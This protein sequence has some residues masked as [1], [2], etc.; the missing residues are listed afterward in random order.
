MHRL[1]DNLT[2]NSELF[3]F[4][5]SVTV[6]CEIPSSDQMISDLAVLRTDVRKLQAAEVSR[7]VTFARQ[8]MHNDWQNNPAAIFAK[9]NPN[10]VAPTYIL[11]DQTGN[12]TGNFRDL[13][14]LLKDAWLPI[15]DKYSD[16]NEPSWEAF[17]NRYQQYFV[18]DTR[19]T[20]RPFTVTGLRSVLQKMKNR[21]AAGP[22][23]W[24]PADL[25][26]LPDNILELVVNLFEAIEAHKQWPA[27]MTHG[28]CCL[29]PKTSGDFSPLG[30]RPLGIMSTLYRLFCCFRL[31]DVLLWQESILHQD[32]R[33]FRTGHSCD[34]IYY[35][36]ALSIEEALLNG[37]DLIGLHFDYQKAFDLIPRNIIFRLAKIQG[38]DP[39]LLAV[40]E[41]MYTR[42]QRYFKI[43]GGHSAPFVSSCGILQG[44]PLSVV[45][46]NIL[47]AIWS[48][49][50]ARESSAHPKAF[51]DDSMALA[52]NLLTAQTAMD[53]TGEVARLTKQQLAAH[54]TVAWATSK[55]SRV[56][57]RKTRFQ[58][59]L[60]QVFS[61]IKALELSSM[62]PAPAELN[63]TV[64]SCSKPLSWLT[65]SLAFHFQ[66]KIADLFV[67]QKFSPLCYLDLNLLS[68]PNLNLANFAVP[69][70]VLFGVRDPVAHRTSF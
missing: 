63:I 13:Q 68:L 17:Q 55:E 15:F 7:R 53:I 69:L 34:D 21:S 64:L 67:L 51:A 5:T 2:S 66:E 56:S 20:L 52:D 16:C 3:R 59:Q 19:M 65:I 25:K 45:F 39:T 11:Q 6:S 4:H 43:P 30:Q 58:D 8:K 44:C 28:F 49:A 48:K 33:G 14:R 36:I 32:Q 70:H 57:L 37:E 41:N 27:A 23:F 18:S 61:T 31:Q 46:M 42:L 40:M 35:Q 47:M 12:L 50:I 54:K 22:D 1:W 29:I 38:F 60:L 24:A 26:N 10:I 9:V 62:L